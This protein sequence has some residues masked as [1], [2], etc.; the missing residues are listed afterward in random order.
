MRGY[1]CWLDEIWLSVSSWPCRNAESYS[2]YWTEAST[3]RLYKR[4]LCCGIVIWGLS[5]VSSAMINLKH[6]SI[7]A[8]PWSKNPPKTER[9]CLIGGVLENGHTRK[10]PSSHDWLFTGVIASVRKQQTTTLIEDIL[11]FE[12][13]SD[14]PSYISCERGCETSQKGAQSSVTQL[15]T[16]HVLCRNK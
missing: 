7:H 2:I 12:H 6:N 8:P 4:L 16:I 5:S 9:G 15:V 10:I 14:C 11:T 3:G 13:A 1:L